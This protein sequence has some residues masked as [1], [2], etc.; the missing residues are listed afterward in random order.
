MKAPVDVSIINKMIDNSIW[1]NPA[2]NMILKFAN[3]D[4]LFING[5]Y[6]LHYSL[7]YTNNNI[8]IQWGK[9]SYKV[10]YIN[11]FTLCLY[12]NEEKF[13]ITVE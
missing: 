11:D 3:G 7:T 6:H 13:W 2:N 5:T 10:D 8:I 1:V 12:N 4:N 9:E